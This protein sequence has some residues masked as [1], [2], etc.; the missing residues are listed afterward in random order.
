LAGLDTPSFFGPIKFSDK[1]QNLTKK[2][3]V[4]QIQNGKPVAVWPKDA[5]EGSLK[6][7]G[8]AA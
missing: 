8:T 5:A 1:G 2:M 3:G 4:I 7:P 6:W